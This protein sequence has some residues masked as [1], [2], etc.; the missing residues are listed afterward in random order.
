[1]LGLEGILRDFMALV[2]DC[3]TPLIAP[4]LIIVVALSISYENNASN[5]PASESESK[6]GAKYSMNS[7]VARFCPSSW[8]RAQI[9]RPIN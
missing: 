8:L 3:P 1:M 4:S 2:K 9:V 5:V 7:W 6:K